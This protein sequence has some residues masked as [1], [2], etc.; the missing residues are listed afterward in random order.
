M[1][2]LASFAVAS[3]LAVPAAAAAPRD[4]LLRLAPPDAALVVVVQNARDH[5][6]NLSGSPFV[7]WFPSTAIGQK[8]LDSEDLKRLRESA[9]MIFAQL[10]TTP[11][12]LVDD[13]LGDAV[14]FAY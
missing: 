4:E 8:L 10:G 11:D 3:L 1:F 6:R 13:V 5:Y 12:A 7:A 14:G 9:G 2:R